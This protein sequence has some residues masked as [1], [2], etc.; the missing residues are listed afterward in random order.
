MFSRALITMRAAIV[1][2]RRHVAVLI[3]RLCGNGILMRSRLDLHGDTLQRDA[4]HQEKQEEF[5]QELRHG[6]ILIPALRERQAAMI[7]IE[8]GEW[9]QTKC[10]NLIINHFRPQPR[11]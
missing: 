10:P 4:D 3:H 11:V 9:S 7:S 5:A 1:P 2:L 6:P 8:W